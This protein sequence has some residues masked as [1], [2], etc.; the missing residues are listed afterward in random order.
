MN[1]VWIRAFVLVCIFAAI[2]IA[3]EALIRWFVS[4][5]TQSKAI[6]LRL[7]M[8]GMGRG[9]GETMRLLRR[10]NTAVP[11]HLPPLIRDWARKFE[12][13]LVQ[14]QVTIPTARLMLMILIAPICIFF[15]LLLL[16]SLWWGIGI[17]SGR[18]LISFTFALVLGAVLPLMLLNMRATRTRKKMQT[19]FPVALDVFVRGL[20]A[21]H[22]I[23]AALDLLTVEMP[24]PIGS[25]FGL[26]VD[27]VTYGAELRDALQNMAERWD[28]DDM[29]MFVV[30]LSVQSETGGNLAEILENLSQVIR[31]RQSMMMKVRA[32]SSEGRM[33]GVMLT[34]LPILTFVVLFVLNP[35]FF[36]DVANDPMFIPGFASLIILYLV[37]F[38]WIRRM[39][40]LKV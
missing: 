25:Q 22:P 1:P 9:S 7:Q 33:T 35:R 26:A 32:L 19:Q 27:E 14:A 15:A 4:R 28:L 3:A 6:N 38:F 17:C 31:E 12:R 2:V 11:D 40:D 5:R 21:G 20:R 18:I 39:V 8:I 13:M 30:S 24:D 16:M 23:A 10:S 36:L 34:V 37:G 29:R